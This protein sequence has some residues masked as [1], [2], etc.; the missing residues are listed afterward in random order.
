MKKL[1]FL[2]AIFALAGCGKETDWR[3]FNLN[4]EVESIDILSYEAI[5]KFGEWTNGDLDSYHYKF[6][7]DKSGKY[8]AQESY[9]NDVLAYKIVRTRHKDTTV[10][11]NYDRSGILENKT[12]SIEKDENNSIH[13]TYDK[14]G[15]IMYKYESAKI[16]NKDTIIFI[17]TPIKKSEIHSMPTTKIVFNKKKD[18]AYSEIVEHSTILT[19]EYLEFDDKENWTKRISTSKDG[20]K[21]INVRKINYY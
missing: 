4:G 17:H 16:T 14:D 13:T 10:L 6:I 15:M 18:E 1:V 2:I 19:Y 20:V 3:K 12:I 7:F 5:N 21:E 11:I 8:I 9:Y